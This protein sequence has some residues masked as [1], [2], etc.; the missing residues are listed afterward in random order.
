[1]ALILLFGPQAK[2]RRLVYETARKQRPVAGLPA[3]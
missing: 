3:V 1:V 2:T